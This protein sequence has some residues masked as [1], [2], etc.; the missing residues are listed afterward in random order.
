[1]SAAPRTVSTAPDLRQL[2]L[3]LAAVLVAIALVIAVALARPATKTP[4]APDGPTTVQYDHGTSSMTSGTTPL[5][6]SGTNA[7]GIRY[8]GIPYQAV[9]RGLTVHGTEGGGIRYTGIPYA[10]PDS[11]PTHG[12]RGTRF[13][14]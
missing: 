12:G 10:A 1:M 14:Q 13:A 9:Q 4:S 11:T 7:G 3:A 8:T 6:V 5:T 2:G